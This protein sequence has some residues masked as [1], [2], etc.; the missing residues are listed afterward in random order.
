MACTS[1]ADAVFGPRVSIACRAFDFTLYFED[2]FLSCLPAALFLALLPLEC[3][4]LR[5]E[6]LRV[7][8]SALLGCS[9]RRPLC[10]PTRLRPR[11]TVARTRDTPAIQSHVSLPADVLDQLALA[12]AA[13]LSYIHHCRSI[14]PSTLLVIFLSVRS[15]L[16]LA[17]VRTLWLIPTASSAAIPFT[18]GFGCSLLSMMIESSGKESSLAATT[19][20]PATPEPFSGFWTRASFAWLAG[21]F[22]QG[23]V[24]VLSVHDLP[25]LEPQLDSQL[26]AQK[27]QHSWAQV[28]DKSAKYA[29]LWS[30]FRAYTYPFLSGVLPRLLVSGFTFCQPFLINATVSW[31]EIPGASPDSGKALIGAYALV[32]LGLAIFTALYGYY[33]FRFTIRLRGGLISLIH[34]QTMRSRAVDLGETTAITLMGTDVERIATGFREIHE[35]WACP[36]DIGIAIYLLERQVGVACLVPSLIAVAF[37]S[38]TFKLSAASNRFQRRWVEKVQERLRLT[39]YTLENIKSVK[40]LGLSERIF[41]IIQGSRYA[42]IVTSAAFRKLL[43]GIITLSNS[44]ADLAPMATFLVYVIIALVRQDNSIL[45]AQAFT[46]LSLISLMTTPM[47]TFI[48][49]VPAVIQCLGCLDRIQEYASAPSPDDEEDTINENITGKHDDSISLQAITKPATEQ[50]ELVKFSNYTV[51]WKQDSP[52]VLREMQLSIQRGDITM[53][54]GPIGSGKSTLLESILGETLVVEGGM[55]ND[56]SCV[57]YCSQTPWLQSETIR[58]NIIG[59]SAIDMEWYSTVVSACGLDKDLARLLEGDQTFLGNN[60]L[61]ISGGQKQRIALARALYSRCKVVLLDDVFSGI[62]AA[63]TELVTRCLFGEKGLFR[64]LQTTVV[65]ATH[66]SFLLHYADNVV[67]LADGTVVDT[68]SLDSLQCR[69]SYIQGLEISPPTES[70]TKESNEVPLDSQISNSQASNEDSEDAELLHHDRQDGDF[71]IYAYYASASG[72]T[73]VLSSLGL[74]FCWSFSR[75][76]PT[77]WLDWW[78]AANAKN[79]N[80]EVGMYLGVYVMLGIAG[81]IFMIAACWLLFVYVVSKSALQLH[82]DLANS[83]MRAPFQ[84]FHKVDIGSITNRFSQDM[85]IIDMKLPLEALNFLASGSTCIVKVTILAAFAKYLG[86]AIPF[87]GVL[88]YMTQKFYLR[89]SRQ[90]R[91]LDIEAKAPLYTHFLE[92]VS[93]A[94]TIRA[95]RWHE[96]F[97]AKLISLLNISQRPVYLLYCAQQCLGFV[98]DVL[99]AVMAVILVA[100]VVFLRDKFNPG[101]VGVALVMVMTFNSS[102]M[103]LIKF[104]TMMET[105]IGAVTRVKSYVATTEPEEPVSSGQFQLPALWPSNGAIQISDFTAAHSVTSSPVLKSISMT[106][107]P[108]EKIAICGSSGSGKTTLILALLRMVEIQQGSITIDGVDI[109]G[110]SRPVIRSRLNVVTQDPFLVAGSV[111]FNIDPFEEA[112]DEEI[113]AA[114]LSLG[115]WERINLDGGLEMEM[116]TAS[117]SLGQRQLLCLARAMVRGGKLLILDEATSSVDHKTEEMMQQALE[118]EFSSHTVLSVLHRLRYI[119]RYDRVAVLDRGVLVEFDTPAALLARNS[120]FSDLYHSRSH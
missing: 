120:R 100:T 13:A 8:R 98:L 73:M 49:A 24:K 15:L 110:C 56:F 71:S 82:N 85:D 51:G 32:Y 4:R 115:L 19:A 105:S 93:G 10:V 109:S 76:F 118:T 45:A 18:V 48:Q 90:L 58:Q 99:V 67:I 106:V 54:V 68:G 2:V 116:N 17:R 88:V 87:M 35:L 52:P 27:L 3:W 61:T 77:I 53:I 84:F 41:S 16:G 34:R 42:E 1:V 96:A 117:W 31:V 101:D 111:R 21:T 39:S 23:Y 59:A 57:A 70:I 119:H 89:N 80:S 50:R 72:V 107:Q 113:T 12:S 30:C 65:L 75:E 20:K 5:N 14:R 25:D 44:P 102:L 112:T 83:T 37:I 74:I 78:S 7:Q 38:M 91:Y 79:P 6:P 108:G 29:L 104:W 22:R 33:T 26:V 63:T 36:I 40:M 28:N 95:F 11:S 69:N 86:I 81:L 9:S 60:G 62:D 46:S 43:V 47:L 94:A 114:L 64:Q 66:S 55:D 92:I 97:N 103:Q